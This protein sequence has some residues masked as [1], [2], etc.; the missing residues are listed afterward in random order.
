MTDKLLDALAKVAYELFRDA[1]GPEALRKAEGRW[2]SPNAARVAL[3]GLV[4]EDLE[5]ALADAIR[6]IVREELDK[7]A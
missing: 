4:E 6:E 2:T 3:F 1:L 7:R 5:T